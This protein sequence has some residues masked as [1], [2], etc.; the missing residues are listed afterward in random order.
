MG[1]ACARVT[2]PSGLWEESDS[3]A[4]SQR[5][6]VLPGLQL[7]PPRSWHSF[8]ELED[9]YTDPVFDGDRH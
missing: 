7:L 2:S 4:Q 6:R 8:F 3:G 5:E 9:S 1:T